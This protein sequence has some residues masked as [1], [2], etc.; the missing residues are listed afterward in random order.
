[1]KYILSL[2]AIIFIVGCGDWKSQN[3]IGGDKSEKPHEKHNPSSCPK[4][5]VGEY[6]EIPKSQDLII[7]IYENTKGI[8]IGLPVFKGDE[9]WEQVVIADG[10]QHAPE[11]KAPNSF[12]I[13]CVKDY[14]I[15]YCEDHKI[16]S[17]GVMKGELFKF[18]IVKTV[19]GFN[20]VREDKSATQKFKKIK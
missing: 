12:C 2:A 6:E 19:E 9:M 13:E 10:L 14:K 8:L 3:I 5:L 20:F 11:S 17:Y 4:E 15:A 18:T 16:V 1:M 7:K